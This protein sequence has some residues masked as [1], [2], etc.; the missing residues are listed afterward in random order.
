M[1][2]KRQKSKRYDARQAARSDIGPTSEEP[3]DLMEIAGAGPGGVPEIDVGQL[4]RI[5]RSGRPVQ[6]VDVREAHEW[7]ISNLG[8]AG[9]TL[10]PLGQLFDRLNELDLDSDMVVYCRTGSRSGMDVTVYS[11]GGAAPAPGTAEA[12]RVSPVTRST[13][14]R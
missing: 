13:V 9:A 2:R 4:E 11:G 7:E 12:S 14:G 6:L 8:F 1:G 3:V 10:I 5:I